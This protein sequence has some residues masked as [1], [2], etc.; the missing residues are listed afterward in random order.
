MRAL[1][2][3]IFFTI[4]IKSFSQSGNTFKKNTLLLS[5]LL[6]TLGSEIDTSFKLLIISGDVYQNKSIEKFVNEKHISFVVVRSIGPDATYPKEPVKSILIDI[7]SNPFLATVGFMHTS[8]NAVGEVISYS[9]KEDKPLQQWEYDEK[10]K[11][12]VR[13]DNADVQTKIYGEYYSDTFG[14]LDIKPDNNYNWTVTGGCSHGKIMSDTGTY[15]I[16]GDTAFTSSKQ[17]RQIGE[18][19]YL[20]KKLDSDLY[21]LTIIYRSDATLPKSYSGRL[22]DYEYMG[23]NFRCISQYQQK[24]N[25]EFVKTR[26]SKKY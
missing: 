25:G 1:L 6:D 24:E 7:F 11:G 9:E 21:C 12:L 10:K 4:S 17:W 5:K 3:I 26:I 14:K 20:I 13:I 8:Y 19:K 15:W 2:L 18:Q 23:N 16:Q 22:N